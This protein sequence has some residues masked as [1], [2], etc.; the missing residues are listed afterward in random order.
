MGLPMEPS[1][2]AWTPE[3]EELQSDIQAWREAMLDLLAEDEDYECIQYPQKF[4]H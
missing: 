2:C 3:G 4:S 1:E